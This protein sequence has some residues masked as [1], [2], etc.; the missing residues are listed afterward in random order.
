M[1]VTMKR[2]A[3]GRWRDGI[4]RG[5]TRVAFGRLDIVGQPIFGEIPLI[6]VALSHFELMSR[7]TCYTL[8]QI[9]LCEVFLFHPVSF[10][11]HTWFSINLVPIFSHSPQYF[12]PLFDVRYF[13]DGSNR[14]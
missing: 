3:T 4:R 10:I 11:L 2:T 9:A 12:F 7:S 1:H 5:Q 8:R 14:F 6:S 13:I